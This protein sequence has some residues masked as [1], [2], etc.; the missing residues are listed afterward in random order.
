MVEEVTVYNMLPIGSLLLKVQRERE[1]LDC[2]YFIWEV[3]LGITSGKV[4][5]VSERK[6]KS[7]QRGVL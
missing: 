3:I 2:K 6:V 5:I 7:Q 4:E 1:K